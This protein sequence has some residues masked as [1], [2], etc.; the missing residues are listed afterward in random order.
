MLMYF[1]KN[2]L[3]RVVVEKSK[4]TYWIVD[5]EKSKS[6]VSNAYFYHDNTGNDLTKGKYLTK[7]NFFLN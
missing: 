1:L 2:L 3:H 4:L 5:L 6:I 7:E